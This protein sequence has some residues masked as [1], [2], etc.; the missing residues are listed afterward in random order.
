MAKK[1]AAKWLWA[2][3]PML[4]RGELWLMYVGELYG[5]LFDNVELVVGTQV[6][7]VL[8]D[9]LRGEVFIECAHLIE[10]VLGVENGVE[11]CISLRCV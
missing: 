6:A 2:V 1:E 9:Q 11:I 7:L 10:H 4:K 3:L 8:A 5:L